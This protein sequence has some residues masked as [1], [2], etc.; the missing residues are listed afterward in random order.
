MTILRFGPPS[1][2]PA[3][4]TAALRPDLARFLA[5]GRYPPAPLARLEAEEIEKIARRVAELLREERG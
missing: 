4:D 5:E 2:H 1:A 3:P